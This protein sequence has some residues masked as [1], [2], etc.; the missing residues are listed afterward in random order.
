MTK[1]VHGAHIRL[2]KNPYYWD[3]ANIHL[4]VLD[5]PYFTADPTASI[6]LFR[7]GK[8]AM[9]GIGQENLD[10]AQLERWKIKS[11]AEGTLFY[12]E[13]NHRAGRLTRNLHLRKALQYTLDSSELVNRVVK[14]PGYL[15]GASLFPVW[16]DGVNAKFRVEYP[17]EEIA[18][19]PAEARRNLAL[20]KRD[21]G[22]QALP[23]LTL[24]ADDGPLVLKQAQ[25]IQEKLKRELG[26][27]VRIDSQIF[28]QR[29]AK[30]EAGDFDMVIAGWGPDYADPLTFGDLFSS[31]NE[32]NRGRYRNPALDRQVEIARTFVDP[33]TR[34]DAFGKIQQIVIDDAVILPLYERARL[35]VGDPRLQGVVRRVTGA[36][37]DFTRARIVPEGAR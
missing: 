16:L 24:L 7:S 1:W 23:P 15:P 32:N 11:F 29:L 9:T 37:P 27:N 22:R 17:V 21:L 10:E 14:I 31:D 30:M 18:P 3:R 12:I 25:Y 34:M 6:N 33:R 36:D 4:E 26:L 13:F 8:I 2:E 35:G 19:D 5:F 20:A 28:K